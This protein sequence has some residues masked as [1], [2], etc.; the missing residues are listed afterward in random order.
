MTI[1][2]AATEGTSPSYTTLRNQQVANLPLDVETA[3]ELQHERM[4]TAQG[5][6]RV[7]SGMYENYYCNVQYLQSPP[8]Y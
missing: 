4:S 2:G 6:F 7:Y 3:E 1:P 5:R 8:A